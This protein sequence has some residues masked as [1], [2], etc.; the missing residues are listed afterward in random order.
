MIPSLLGGGA[1][2]VASILSAYAPQYS[3]I[4]FI[5]LKKSAVYPIK[6]KIH[7]LGEIR[8]WL[9][10]ASRLIKFSKLI[11]TYRPSCI[12]IFYWGLRTF[13]YFILLN[14]LLSMF[15]SCQKIIRVSNYNFERHILH[16]N[17]VK[18]A[19]HRAM[20]KAMLNFSVDKII[21]IS[22]AI[23]YKLI[24]KYSVNSGKI[25]VIKNPVDLSLIRSC[26]KEEVEDEFREVFAHPVVLN[27]GRM[28]QA[29]GQWHLIRLFKQV[30]SE[31]P[32]ARL[33]I[34]GDGPLRRYL[35]NLIHVLGLNGKVF[36][37]GWRSNPFKYMVRSF[38]F[39]LPSLWEGFP[40]VIVESLACGLPV[41]ASD[42]LS[43]PREILAP[44]TSYKVKKLKSP[45]YADYGILMPPMDGKKYLSDEPLSWQEELWAREII[46]LMKNPAVLRRY[47]ER[48]IKRAYDFDAGKIVSEYFSECLKK[49]LS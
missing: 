37:L 4:L 43:G 5:T 21:A 13:N 7:P 27:V 8:N 22:S 19:I 10:L 15:F 20:I 34:I 30:V 45:E 42:C 44:N 2:R 36:L 26:V 1:E 16:I 18:Q 14:M 6:H 33:I 24:N 9:D 23:R 49:N 28:V 32:D 12:I 47:R 41:M 35:G 31:V 46:K 3:D 38:L 39:C 17:R 48:G 11:L 29:K 25:A 40:N